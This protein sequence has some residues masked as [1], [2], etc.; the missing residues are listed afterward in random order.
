MRQQLKW[1]PRKE[2]TKRNKYEPIGI[3]G[4]NSALLWAHWFTVKEVSGI[5]KEKDFSRDPG[6]YSEEK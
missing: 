4:Y 6:L 5:V 3:N 2:I 1:D